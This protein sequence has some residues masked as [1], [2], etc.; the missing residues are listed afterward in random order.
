M[1]ESEWEWVRERVC[2]C[3]RERERK[4]VRESEGDWVRV[5]ARESVCVCEREREREREREIVLILSR[6]SF[7]LAGPHYFESSG[8][9]R[10]SNSHHRVTA[11]DAVYFLGRQCLPQSSSSISWAQKEGERTGQRQEGCV[12]VLLGCSQAPWIWARCRFPAQSLDSSSYPNSGLMKTAEGESSITSR[13]LGCPWIGSWIE[14]N[15]TR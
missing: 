11:G 3:V 2:V 6:F 1:R 10:V 12:L 13:G 4:R 9:F 8:L 14:S 7:L 5:S 15:R